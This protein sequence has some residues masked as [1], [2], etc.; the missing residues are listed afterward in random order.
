[1]AD[2]VFF[3]TP[4]SDNIYGTAGNDILYGN[5]GD[6]FI[7]GG[8]GN[9]VLDGG[10]GND[11][12]NGDD[13]RDVLY[14]NDSNDTLLGGNADDQLYGGDGDDILYGENG[15]DRLD[16]GAGR[17]T[18]IGGAGNDTYTVYSQTDIVLEAPGGGNDTIQSLVSWRLPAQVENLT[19]LGKNPIRGQGN[20]QDNVIRGNAAKNHLRGEGGNDRLIGGRGQDILTGGPGADRFDFE[21]RKDG[22]DRI[23]DFS[24]ADKIG[25]SRAG[26]S[27]DFKVGKTI[28]PNQFCIGATATRGSDRVIYD[29]G[30]EVL[31][32]DKDGSGPL[33]QIRLAVLSGR[34]SLTYRNIVAF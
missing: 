27:Q 6:D 13:G 34:P 11:S 5:A 28:A 22:T 31:F 18:L 17:N 25:L 7:S 20:P 9:D 16:G 4:G 3:G 19:L 8:S 1:M 12:L 2:N 23:T 21:T 14:G 15:N 10:S 30:Q 26:F 33:R 29:P 24:P 32:F